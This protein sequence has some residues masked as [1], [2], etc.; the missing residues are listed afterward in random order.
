MTMR[1]LILLTFTLLLSYGLS[2]A[3]EISE[4]YVTSDTLQVYFRQDKILL[5]PQFR[6]NGTRLREFSRQFHKLLYDP[7]NKVRSIL[8]VSGASPEGP[9]TR[10]KY[11]SDNRAKVVYD[12][13]VEQ[14]LADPTHIEIESRGVDWQGLKARVEKSDLPYKEDVLEILALPEWISKDGKVVDGRKA[15]LMTYQGGK[16]WNELYNL[17]FADLRGTRVMIAY[18]ILKKDVPPQPTPQAI[19]H[20]DTVYVEKRDTVYLEKVDTVYVNNINNHYNTFINLVPS[21]TPTK[22]PKSASDKQRRPFYMAI[23]TNLVY[24]GLVIPNIGAE[25]GIAKGFVL[26]GNY[27]NIWL[28]D[29][30]WTRW[31]RIEGFEAGLKWYFNK[32]RRPFKGHHLELYGQML[33]WDITYDGKG[34]MADRWSYGGGI[35]YGYALPIGRRFNLDF[36]IGVGYLSGEMHRYTPQDGHRVWQSLEKFE[37]IGPTK[38][39]I[40]L[41]WLIGRGNK[42]ERRLKER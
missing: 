39:G 24:D 33:T 36:E 41:Q 18:N 38:V 10:N 4:V 1:R 23:K 13:L 8:I 31:Y 27:Q 42:H 6:D 28:R 25:I 15:R 34:Y 35:G 17:Y 3:Q 9:S 20:T 2:F 12:Y 29:K 30:D 40:T 7:Q 21:S 32:E 26:S 11:L 22:E 37:W 19:V 14:H 5:E 16:V